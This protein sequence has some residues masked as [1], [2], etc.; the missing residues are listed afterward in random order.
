MKIPFTKEEVGQMI[1]GALEAGFDPVAQ[2]TDLTVHKGANLRHIV[3]LTLDCG[4]ELKLSKEA[5]ENA[6]VVAFNKDVAPVSVKE[7]LV[8]GIT[9]HQSDTAMAK[10]D[11][12]S[13]A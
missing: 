1:L 10:V 5:I 4:S 2:V 11:V 7:P 3:T 6:I 12:I 9:F 13:K 8:Q